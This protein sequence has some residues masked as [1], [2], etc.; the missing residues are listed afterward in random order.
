M[1]SAAR[2]VHIDWMRQAAGCR[3]QYTRTQDRFWA[4]AARNSVSVAKAHRMAGV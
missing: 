2:K 4:V 3:A 1:A